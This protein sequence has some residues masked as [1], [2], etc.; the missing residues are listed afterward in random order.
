MSER[1]LRGALISPDSRFRS[2]VRALLGEVEPRVGIA[3]EITE[4]F[5]DF[6]EDVVRTLRQSKPDLLLVDLEQ[7]SELGVK[8]IQF[9]ADAHPGQRVIA[10]GGE[11]S[12]D[13]L[14]AAMRAGVADYL[15][16]PVSAELLRGAVGRVAQAMGSSRAKD[17]EGR[18]AEGQVFAFFSPKGGSGSTTVA[19][20]L[21]VVLRQLTNKRTLLVDLDLELGETAL[22]LGM[23]PRFN[24][25]DLV[26]N[27]HRMDA[28]LLASF[29]ERHDSGVDLLSAP[30]HPEKAEM[31]SGDL[32]RRILLFLRQHYDYVVVD[33]SKSF[34]QA[35]L[36]TFEQADQVFLVTTADLPSLRNIQRGLPMMR[37]V[38]VRGEDQLRLVINRFDPKDQISAKDIERSLGL[39]VF[40]KLS[41][42]YE[43]V[44]GSLNTGKPIVMNGTSSYSKDLKNL[45]VALAGTEAQTERRG[46]IMGALSRL[47][48]GKKKD[49]KHG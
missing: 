47:T 11:I 30:Y 15:H 40:W 48:T 42:D 39:K 38:L 8:F 1:S 22:M 9:L 25:V 13:Q 41:N 17:D 35:T 36:A 4:R 33:T 49:G 32:I 28:D 34:S 14:L 44:L 10:F 31:V 26:Q 6:R 37:R 45:G 19:T 5:V 46:R 16:K 18:K 20:N 3:V 7:E 12:P 24:F 23:R 2:E 21:A 27:F 29:I 43:A